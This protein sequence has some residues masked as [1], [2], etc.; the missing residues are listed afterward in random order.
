MLAGKKCYLAGCGGMLGEAFYEEL[1]PGN[2]VEASD[3]NPADPWLRPLDFRDAGAYAEAI[4]R[5]RPDYLFHLGALTDLEYCETNPQEA[6]ETN[7][8]AV[9]T[10]VK[11]ANEN[12][13]KL[14]YIST[15][16]IFDGKKER[17]TEEDQPNP[18]S[19]YAR[20]KY[21]GEMH[22]RQFS[23]DYLMCRP[24]WM[25]GG[26]PK[27]DKKFVRK[28]IDQIRQ[29]KKTIHIVNDKMGTPTYTVDFARNCL[30]LLSM[31][32]TGLYHMVCEGET[33]RLEVAKAILEFLPEGKNIRL[34]EVGS[35]FFANDYFAP[36]PYSEILINKKLQSEGLLRMRSWQEAL[37]EYLNQKYSRT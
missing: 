12:G 27:K 26:G 33:S 37:A 3:K 6:M 14:I 11:L 10:A 15:A 23:K 8:Q 19:Q 9:E 5:F 22:V 13:C 24:G 34:E 7:A 1:A 31:G 20:T 35:E 4:R 32:K 28:I 2:Q 17:Y 21:W 16:G 25:M 30:H 18:I 29:A 36:R